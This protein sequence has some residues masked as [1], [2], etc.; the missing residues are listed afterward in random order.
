MNFRR[1]PLTLF[2]AA[3]VSGFSITAIASD[4]QEVVTGKEVV[5]GTVLN[6]ETQNVFGTVN[7]S[8][9]YSGTQNINQTD[10]GSLGIANDTII[11]GG[12]QHVIGGES[13]NTTINAGGEQ[14]VTR[15]ASIFNG[16]ITNDTT[17]NNGGLQNVESGTAIRTTVK[18]GGVMNVGFDG[19]S[20]TGGARSESSTIDGGEQNVFQSGRTTGDFVINE[21]VQN[22]ND[23]GT[24][25][26]TTVQY[27][28]T[29]NVNHGGETYNTYL[30]RGGSNNTKHG[31]TQN[32]NSGGVANHTYVAV[33]SIQNLDGGVSNYSTIDSGGSQYV[34]NEGVAN[35][36][37]V[38]VARPDPVP[39]NAYQ[40]INAGGVANKTTLT[41]NPVRENASRYAMQFVRARGIANDTEMN[42]Y[43]RQYINYN[44]EANRTSLAGS[45]NIY[46]VNSKSSYAQQ[47]IY[48]G[49]V[50]NKTEL[51]EYSIQNVEG[52]ANDTTLNNSNSWQYVQSGGVAN[53]TTLFDGNS[54]IYKGGATNNTEVKG[55]KISLLTGSLAGGHTYIHDGA[56][57]LM[58]AG[59]RATDVVMNGGTLSI[60]DLTDET[61]SLTPAQVDKLTMDGGSVS[62][63]RDSEGDF[64][65]LNISELN[66]TGNFLF[67]SSLADRNS[68]FVTIEQGSGQFGIAVTDSGKEISD[69][70]DLTVNLIHEQSGDIDFEMVT[71]S[72][73]STRAIDG[74]TYMYTLFSQQDKDGLSGGNVWYLGALTDEPGSENPGGENPGGENPGGENPG[75]GDNGNAGGHGNGG[76]KPMTTPATDAI[77]AMSNAG[78]NV[79]HSEL[80]GLRMYRASLDKT[81]PESN[82]WGHY[83]GSKNNI[84]TSNGAAYKLNQNGIEIGADTRT[85]FDRGSLITGAFMS[86]SDNKVKHARGGKSKIES[87]GLGLYAT[88]FDASG[89]YIDGVMKGNR[90]NNKLSAV[91]T[92]GGKTSS[93]WNQYAFSTAVEGGYQFDLKDDVSIT[94]YARL[95]FVQMTSGDVKLSNGMK[96]NTGTPRS[97]TGE[98]GAKLA[99]K[100]SLGSTEFKPYLSA[101]VVQEFADSNEVT[102][103]ERNRFDNDVKGTSGKYGL[104][105]SV[106]VGKDVTLYGEANYRQGS[107]IETPIQGL[108]G[109]RVSF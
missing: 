14:R 58:E 101:A 37:I 50:A 87:Y 108:A 80:E 13:N 98:A 60:T 84:D 73:R 8:V 17:V 106:N 12:L 75:G 90:L 57:M 9:I 63:L 42:A 56:E 100:F 41:G 46:N 53:R 27:L 45:E 24:T 43:S 69:H 26:Q 34:N 48:S 5:T 86:Y 66:G 97:V 105:A 28:G 77:L 52:T 36:T 30:G 59:S 11:N 96:G 91:M 104:G 99:G 107:N 23:G 85:D 82:V 25:H 22:V 62:F 15:G 103:N 2:I 79:V 40:Y 93:D 55:G 19:A 1:K 6:G 81:G 89:F 71:A 33:G 92:N 67:N 68:N 88:W 70:T 54:I 47:Y 10:V 109:I 44:G 61:S 72:G 29:Q 18:T 51:N 31:G 74:G 95:A 102:I 35:N 7:S 49:G 64:A 65:A 38:L 83:L 16:A 4:V 32:V 3:A 94:P 76:K 39:G 20:G 78:L 21:G